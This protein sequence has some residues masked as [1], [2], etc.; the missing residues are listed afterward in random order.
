MRIHLFTI[1]SVCSIC[2]YAALKVASDESHHVLNHWQYRIRESQQ[3][4]DAAR[5]TGGGNPG[6][7][8][9]QC[10]SKWCAFAPFWTV[11]VHVTVLKLSVT[12]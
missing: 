11:L 5:N 3:Q 12:G 2:I 4:Q 1:D 6:S 7:S 8:T 10:A 9:P